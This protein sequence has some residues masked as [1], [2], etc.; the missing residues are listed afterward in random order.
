MFD[1]NGWDMF[2]AE[3]RNFKIQIGMIIIV[4]DML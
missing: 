4:G 3:E 2:S 1:R